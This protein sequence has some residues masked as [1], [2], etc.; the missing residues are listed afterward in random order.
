[1]SKG[2]LGWAIWWVWGAITLGLGSGIGIALGSI[3]QTLGATVS[4]VTGMGIILLFGWLSKAIVP[5]LQE[6][7]SQ[8]WQ[9]LTIG[10]GFMVGAVNLA[11]ATVLLPI[12]IWRIV[13]PFQ[14]VP[15]PIVGSILGAI[16]AVVGGIVTGTVVGQQ[17]QH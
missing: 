6:S 15:W 7:L 9:R 8:R 17:S 14:I 13:W 16:A 3:N 1:M 2:M 10:V 11:V 5:P 12:A 4:V